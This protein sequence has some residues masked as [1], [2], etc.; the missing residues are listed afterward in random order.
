M[1]P[2]IK[3]AAKFCL[4]LFT[5][6]RRGLHP[7]VND[8]AVRPSHFGCAVRDRPGVH[9]SG[10]GELAD[11]HVHQ[12]VFDP[13]QEAVLRIDP[14]APLSSDDVGDASEPGCPATEEIRDIEIGVADRR[15]DLPNTYDCPSQ[16]VDVEQVTTTDDVEGVGGLP[17]FVQQAPFTVQTDD[18]RPIAAPVE[19]LDQFEQLM[20]GAPDLRA[21]N[22]VENVERLGHR[23][24]SFC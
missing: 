23:V 13:F 21:R 9:G 15:A 24:R 20:F 4:A 12:P 14:E 2:D 8:F 6:I 11:E 1:A 18:V 19:T 7:V 5:Q 16:G 10:I 22:D 17:E 3:F